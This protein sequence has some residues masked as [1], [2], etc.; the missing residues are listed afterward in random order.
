MPFVAWWAG[1]LSRAL[2]TVLVQVTG[3]GTHVKQ[4]LTPDFLVVV[5]R[6]VV[7]GLLIV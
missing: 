4:R 3:S 1:E 6:H 7:Q 5:V 2:V